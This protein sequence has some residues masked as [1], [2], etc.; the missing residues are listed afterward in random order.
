MSTTV[1]TSGSVSTP[2]KA[3]HT[4]SSAIYG[5]LLSR[6]SPQPISTTKSVQ[7]CLVDTDIHGVAQVVAQMI[8]HS[9]TSQ[10]HKPILTL[11]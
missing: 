7:F 6:I 9:S 2:S 3:G 10:T 11:T 4:G 1:T 5:G 8:D